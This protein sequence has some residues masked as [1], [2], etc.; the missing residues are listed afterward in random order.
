[1]VSFAESG[2]PELLWSSMAEEGQD[3]WEIG[4]TRQAARTEDSDIVVIDE[5]TGTVAEMAGYVIDSIPLPTDD[6]PALFVPLQE[7][8][9]LAPESWYVNVLSVY[10]DHRGKGHGTRLLE[11][12]ER[13]ARE[14]RLTR[15]SIIVADDN[16]GA[17]RLYERCG[18][19]KIAARQAVRE[20]WKTDTKQWI[21]LIKDLD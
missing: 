18:Y 11:I 17:R 16:V 21:L 2:L 15:S 6:M 20:G 10:P 1:M 14:E 12:A 7:L 19:S 3:P 4:R 13:I 5:G 8:E 9:N